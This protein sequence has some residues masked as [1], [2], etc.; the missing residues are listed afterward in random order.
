MNWP[1]PTPEAQ[2]EFLRNVQRLLAEG[3][4]VASN[5]FALVRA[6]AD[7]AVLQGDDSGAPLDLD[8]KDI[9]AKFVESYWRQSRPFQVGGEA[10]GLI[11]QQNT[12][13]QA[14]IIS[15]IVR[16][17]QE[18]GTSL[19]RF[20]QEAPG[21]WAGLVDGVE[22]VVCQM[23]LWKLQTVGD[24]RL[25]FLYA[26][27]NHGTRITLKPGVAYCFRAFY[28]LV[29]DLIE[30]A[31]V[32]FIQR[33]NAKRLG[34]YCL[35]TLRGALEILASATRAKWTRSTGSGVRF[36]ARPAPSHEMVARACG[37]CAA[38]P[39]GSRTARPWK[40]PR[41]SA[42]FGPRAGTSSNAPEP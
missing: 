13:R 15:Q 34:S 22:Q 14:A 8:T 26:N 12:G 39:C 6:L 32:R 16:S 36:A 42:D 18:C 2:V 29:R 41:G 10:T 4:F 11:L 17:Q 28:E 30:G 23:P 25:E 38:S 5:K 33:A 27:L 40:Y 35:A 24:E 1:V 9:S 3:L 31:W 37:R 7:L 19:F 20:K 21:R